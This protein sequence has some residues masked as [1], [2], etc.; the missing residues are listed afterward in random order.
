[1]NQISYK[2]I[3]FLVVFSFSQWASALNYTIDVPK[4]I[5]EQQIALHMPLEKKL[6]MATLRLSDPRLTLLEAS[7]EVA[8]FLNVEV[9]LVQGLKASGRGELVGSIDYR[10]EEGAF[11]LVNPRII[12]LNIDHLP[13]FLFPKIARAAELLLARSLATYPVYRL[14]EKD[15]RQ[16]MAKAAL[17]QVKVSRD[18]LQL[19]LGMF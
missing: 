4:K 14:N 10:P 16:K 2:G 6:L 12:N 17:K 9:W 8:L 7:N 19:T 11:Y 3:V 1:M 18:T 15:T 13:A 5:I